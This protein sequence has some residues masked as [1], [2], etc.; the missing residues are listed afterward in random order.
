M[1]RTVVSRTDGIDIG[2][3]IEEELDALAV[4]VQ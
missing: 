2:M 4:A 1:K 3:P